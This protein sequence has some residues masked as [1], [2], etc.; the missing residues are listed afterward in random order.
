[1]IRLIFLLLFLIV[2]FLLSL[3]I[4]LVE[5]IVQQFN[6][7][8]RNRTSLA[9][10]KWALRV[11]AFISGVKLEVN[12]YENIPQ[13]QPVLFIG[14]HISIYDVI[15]TYP[16][17][18][19]PT[20]YIAKKEI[21]KVPFLNIWMYFVNCIFIDRTDARKGLK[22]ILKATEHINSGI[23]IVLFPEG[24]RSK[25]GKILP[26]KDGGFKIASKT[27]CPVVPMGITGTADIFENH[28]P[29]IKPS[30]VTVNFGEPIYTDSMSKDELKHL[31][32][33][34]YEEV[35]ALSGQASAEE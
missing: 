34:V 14:N 3:P 27:S 6:M 13:D 12:G 9:C 22:A 19:N 23:S 21:Q 25:D 18:K 7:D 24:T 28:I 31:S 1:M 2:Y 32:S 33:R 20:G 29:R 17:M 10:V 26:F 5:F 35:K 4:Q 8:F 30:H 15:I 16:L 11:V